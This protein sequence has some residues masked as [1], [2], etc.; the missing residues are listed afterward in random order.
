MKNKN[1]LHLILGASNGIGRKFFNFISDK[2]I[3]V[4]GTGYQ[5]LSDN[6]LVYFDALNHNF[7]HLL[8][9]LPPKTR[10]KISWIH[11]FYG[12]SNPNWIE[13]NPS[14][15]NILNVKSK[16]SII[17][18]AI[19]NNINIGFPSTDYVFGG[20]KDSYTETDL[21]MPTTLYGKQKLEIEKYITENTKN[22]L[23]VRFSPNIFP[24]DLAENCR[25]ASVY[26]SIL[27]KNAVMAQ[28]VRF[29]LTEVSDTCRAYYELIKIP[30]H[31]L[32]INS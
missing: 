25:V 20:D 10:S 6:R 15:S 32:F 13:K 12:V 22:H 31:L 21:L 9:S 14:I 2:N 4:L 5:N 19:K 17:N 18:E 7:N 30:V 27:Q 1:A 24:G 26:K 16:L 11:L 8:G 3:Q 28:D 29:N 23:I